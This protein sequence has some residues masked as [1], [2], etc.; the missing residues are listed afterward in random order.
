M[1]E[2]SPSRVRT[3]QERRAYMKLLLLSRL[4]FGEKEAALAIGIDFS[5]A[6][7]LSL[8]PSAQEFRAIKSNYQPER[9]RMFGSSTWF[10]NLRV[11]F[12]EVMAIYDV[13]AYQ[14]V[15]VGS[16]LYT[17]CMASTYVYLKL[18]N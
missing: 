1:N 17:T 15:L 14:H 4:R 16:D 8:S 5:I 3:P 12:V 2:P 13:H 7:D 18:H 9:S 10:S 6:P 11:T